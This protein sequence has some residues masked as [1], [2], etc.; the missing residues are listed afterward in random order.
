M[1]VLQKRLRTPRER[2]VWL[3]ARAEAGGGEQ[4]ASRSEAHGRRDAAR[5]FHWDSRL[6]GRYNLTS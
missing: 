4:Q 3:L 6:S 2:K 1:A 5:E